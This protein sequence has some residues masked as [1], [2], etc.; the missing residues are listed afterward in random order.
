[1]SSCIVCSISNRLLESHIIYESESVIC[2]LDHRP[3]SEGHVLLCPKK[4]YPN[5][6]DLPN[7]ILFEIFSL[8]KK[9]ALFL[10]GKFKCDGVSLLQNNGLFNDLGHFHLHLF[11]RFNGDGFYWNSPNDEVFSLDKLAHTKKIFIDF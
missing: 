6:M 11:P 2:F 5:I 4:H 7:E 8:A 3:I 10:Q 9:M 1:M